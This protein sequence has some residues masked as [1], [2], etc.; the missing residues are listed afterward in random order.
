M[1]D[2]CEIQAFP[3]GID[4]AVSAARL[5]MAA[6]SQ[7][8]GTQMTTA[9]K[10]SS[11]SATSPEVASLLDCLT[12]LDGKARVIVD[13]G[14][15]VQASSRNPLPQASEAEWDRARTLWPD[16]QGAARAGTIARLLAVRGDETEIA[17]MEPPAGGPPLLVRAAAVDEEHVCLVLAIPGHNGL[18]RIADLQKLFGLTDCEARIVADLM[19]GRAPQ[20]IAKKRSNSIH[21][22]R[23]HIRQCHQKIGVKT[24]EEMFSRITSFCI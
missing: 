19:E 1:A 15:K 4:Q 12:R 24:K 10:T 20:A 17:V 18:P 2:P 13:R 21:T 3:S 16:G 23:A 9:H 7:S 14:G 11:Q 6:S 22:I 5:R 8:Q